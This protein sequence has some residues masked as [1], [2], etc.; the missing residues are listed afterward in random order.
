MTSRMHGSEPID[1]QLR[2]G[3]EQLGDAAAAAVVEV[4]G[5][6]RLGGAGGDDPPAVVEGAVGDLDLAGQGPLQVLEIGGDALV[7]RNP[8]ERQVLGAHRL[9]H[10]RPRVGH[11][12]ADVGL[13]VLGDEPL[14]ARLPIAGDQ[15]GL[16]AAYRGDP[17]ERGAILREAHG[18]GGEIVLVL[19]HHERL[20]PGAGYAIDDVPALLVAR[21][22]GEPRMQLAVQHDAGQLVAVLVQQLALARADVD[23]VDVVPGLVAVVE[24]DRQH[25]RLIE[26][27]LLDAGVDARQRR[28]VARR[29]A[30][31][32]HGKNV[33]VL[34]AAL[35]LDVEHVRAAVGPGVEADAALPVVGED[36]RGAHVAGRRHP[37]VEHAVLGG[38][39][40]QP[41]S[42]RRDLALRARRVAEQPRAGNER[43]RHA[44]VLFL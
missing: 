37:D 28:E 8:V 13:G 18:A 10:A 25:V 35:V 38:E 7:E 16:V 21:L 22:E 31:D 40:G 15:R 9:D 1:L 19:D 24:P 2:P 26:A 34:G 44:R 43:C 27:Q 42:V 41:A 6:G 39:P 29:P 33:P 23:A 32:R 17:V 14:L 12:A 3:G 5:G 30:L 11:D 20:E 36:A 4:I